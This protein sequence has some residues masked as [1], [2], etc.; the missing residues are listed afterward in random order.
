MLRINV[1]ESYQDSD[2]KPVSADHMGSLE[3][4]VETYAS[5]V[6]KIAYHLHAKMP[7]HVNV[8]DLIQS[9][10]IGLIDAASKYD[11]SKGASFETYAG[12][13]IRGSI[14][15]EVRKGDWTPRSVY[16]NSRRVSQAMRV[17]ENRL[18]RDAKDSEIAA[19]MDISLME[20]YDILK[21]LSA[22][23]I[24]SIS[25]LMNAEDNESGKMPHFAVADNISDHELESSDLSGSFSSFSKSNEP[26]RKIEKQSIIEAISIAIEELPERERQ[27]LSL[28]Y[29][30]ELNLKEIGQVF[31]ISESRISQIHSQAI[32]RLR[33]KLP[34][35]DTL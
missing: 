25:E 24:F 26:H 3:S 10:M 7:S 21:D 23:R 11:D 5:L 32:I 6:R 28:Y 17:I 1:S 34:D 4:I 15:D 12:I 35:W 8:N 33:S 29:N 13:R 30:E 31:E 16:K 27:I 2:S 14:L 20:Y 18:G 19:E 22:V 9:G